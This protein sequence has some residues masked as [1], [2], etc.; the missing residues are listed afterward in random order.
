RHWTRIRGIG[1]LDPAARSRARA[2]WE[3]RERL[4]RATDTAP[5]RIL[6]DRTLV[7]LA[8]HPVKAPRELARR[9]VRRAAVREFG[10]D[11]IEALDEPFEAEPGPRRRRLT[12][13]DRALLDELRA[14]RT[15]CAKEIGVDPGF[16]CPNRVLGPAILR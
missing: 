14:V 6:A 8:T 1:R 15:A 4:A 10:A 13:A 16:L 7:E 5:G 9:G 2:L 3:T 11:L 12:D